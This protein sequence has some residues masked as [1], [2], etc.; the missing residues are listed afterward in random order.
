MA[1][2]ILPLS[3]LTGVVAFAAAA[4][5][6]APEARADHRYI[7][8]DTSAHRADPGYPNETRCCWPGVWSSGIDAAVNWGNGKAYIFKGSQYIRYNIGE[9]RADPGYPKAINRN[10]WPGVWESGIDAAINWGNGKAYFFKGDQYIRYDIAQNRADPGYPKRVD[11]RNWPGLPA[12]GAIDSAATWGNG[13]AYFFG[14]NGYVRYD[15]GAD[16]ADPGYP[17]AIAGNTW[18][19]VN[20]DFIGAALS[21]HSNKVYFFER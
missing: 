4:L 10:T 11:N 3:L 7:R 19:G 12:L 8:Y 6:N 15:I 13:K 2:C 5:A 18:P 16:R 1:R 9:D 14:R 21:W 17:K 20:F